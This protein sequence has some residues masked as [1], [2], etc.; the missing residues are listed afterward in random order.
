MAVK[1]ECLSRHCLRA[2]SGKGLS[3]VDTSLRVLSVEVDGEGSFVYRC[4]N[5]TPD[6]IRAPAAEGPIGRHGRSLRRTSLLT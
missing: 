6:P 2:D 3:Q 4:L 5:S 1:R